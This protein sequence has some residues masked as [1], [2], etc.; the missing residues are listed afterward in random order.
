MTVNQSPLINGLDQL[1]ADTI[2]AMGLSNM[3]NTLSEYDK[4]LVLEDAKEMLSSG[5]P[6]FSSNDK[7]PKELDADSITSSFDYGDS[8]PRKE[9]TSSAPRIKGIPRGDAKL[10]GEVAGFYYLIGLGLTFYNK[11]DAEIV[12]SNAMDRAVE[13]VRVANHH[14]P[15]K[16]WLVRFTRS[17]DYTSMAIGHGLMILAIFANHKLVPQS[18]AAAIPTLQGALRQVSNR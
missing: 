4:E 11:E 10:V 18:V 8:T 2:D 15:F 5:F 17:S 12:F 3:L 9:R 13:L 14:Q 1:S 16:A 6:V 7:P